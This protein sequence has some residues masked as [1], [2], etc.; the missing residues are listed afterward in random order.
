M[1]LLPLTILLVTGLL[2]SL[3][4]GR[5]IS[6]EKSP[7]KERPDASVKLVLD[8]FSQARLDK[9]GNLVGLEKDSPTPV[10][11]WH[12]M[13]DTAY[14]SI[15]IDRMALQKRWPRMTVLSIQIGNNSVE[16]ELGGYFVNVNYQIELACKEILNN[17][18]IK[19][20]GAI[21]AVG[22]SQGAQFLRGLIQ[23][24]PLKENGIRVKNFISLGGQ[25]QGVFGLPNCFQS[26]FCSHI[27]FLLSHAAYEGIVQENLVQ[28]E[29][30]HDPKRE[31]LYKSKNVYLANIN[32]ENTINETYKSSLMELE[33]FVLVEFLDD[34][35]VVPRESSLF[36]F[37][38]PGQ[39]EKIV[40]L[41]ESAL[42]KED[43][44]GLR[45][46]DQSKRLHQIKLPG[47]HLQYSMSWFINEIASVYLIN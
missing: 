22:F 24:C 1:N 7:F 37:Y 3:C 30:W 12:G 9:R 4:D 29:Y 17:P 16:D 26:E 38:E 41:E 44:L 27:R 20:H 47:R 13:G 28:A 40:P 45:Q 14:G 6:F 43:R 42:Y 31:Q 21:N 8:E 46:L 10:V 2:V 33:N 32:N 39:T 5:Q 23:R 19:Q 18:I 36:G 34:D 35:M 15:N 11:F 25:H